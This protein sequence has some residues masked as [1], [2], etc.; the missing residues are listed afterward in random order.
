[1]AHR[2]PTGGTSCIPLNRYV[3]T[4]SSNAIRDA[5]DNVY[6]SSVFTCFIMIVER[7]CG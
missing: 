4:P 1:M 2:S 3:P 7:T 6:H 5:R